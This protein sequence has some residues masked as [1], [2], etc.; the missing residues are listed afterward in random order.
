MRYIIRITSERG[1]T[2]DCWLHFDWTRGRKY[3]DWWAVS[4]DYEAH[5]MTEKQMEVISEQLR[6]NNY[7]F[8]VIAV[9]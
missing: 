7:G 4:I 8:Q 5:S 9:R 2:I 1:K 3:P 6:N